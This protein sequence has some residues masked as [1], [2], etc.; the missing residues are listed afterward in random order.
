MINFLWE[1]VGKVLVVGDLM[2]DRYWDGQVDR[3][4][5][6]AP[7]P[8]LKFNAEYDNLGGA[9]NVA[10]NI[11]ALGVDVAA[12][13]VVG[14][15]EAG[16][17]ITELF[18]KAGIEHD[19]IV[20]KEATTTKLRLVSNN[21]QIL[22]V[23][24]EEKHETVKFQDLKIQSEALFNSAEVIVCSDYAKGM[25][26]DIGP[27]ID[28]ARNAEVSIIVDPKGDDYEKYRGATLITP[29][30]SEF[31]AVVGTCS[32][33]LVLEQKAYQLVADLNLNA[34]LVTRGKDG[35]SLFECGEKPFHLE[36]MAR[37][38]AD[39]TGAGD[40]VIGVISAMLAAGNSMRDS[41]L[42]G[43]IAAGIVVS[44][45]GAASVSL[46]DISEYKNS[47]SSELPRGLL[48]QDEMLNAFDKA[49]RGTHSIVATNGCFDILHAGHIDYLAKAKQFGDFLIVLVN[50]DKSVSRLKGSGRPVNAL[51]HRVSM[52]LALE[53]VDAVVAFSEDSPA[54]I[55]KLLLPDILVKGADYSLYEVA[56]ADHVIGYGGRVELIDLV[57]GVST[58]SLI[59]KMQGA[60]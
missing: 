53:S 18:N 14:G 7:V 2:L 58:S 44:R 56:G 5:P 45:F 47:R 50:D 4:S 20:S 17:K 1:R 12:I 3:I 9:A 6:E 43:N 54:S 35:M 60:G 31:E 49:N 19:L 26:D 30:F 24:I 40:T 27:L 32:D 11:A 37:D 29:N 46:S 8:V 42:M 16:G 48:R 39:V 36:A 10:K 22:R 23:D 55:Y 33:E 51:K 28:Y 21:H 59:A 34:I 52:L 38:V 15:D 57:Q 25:L 41:V 13:G